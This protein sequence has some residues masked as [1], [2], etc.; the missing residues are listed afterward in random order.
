MPLLQYSNWARILISVYLQL[1]ERYKVLL[2]P[3]PRSCFFVCLTHGEA[4]VLLENASG[5][6]RLSPP[7]A[8]WPDSLLHESQPG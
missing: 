2:V 3:F 1:F 7:G 8:M 5:A 4:L 6:C